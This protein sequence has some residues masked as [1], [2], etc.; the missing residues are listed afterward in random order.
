M[1]YEALALKMMRKAIGID[2]LLEDLA[3]ESYSF[4]VEE[5]DQDMIPEEYRR[6]LSNYEE[7]MTHVYAY[8]SIYLYVIVPL[9][10]RDDEEVLIGVLEEGELIDYD[11]VK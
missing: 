9:E 8:E 7:V 1:N 4:E 6:F 10:R 11:L 2:I 3:V 5:I